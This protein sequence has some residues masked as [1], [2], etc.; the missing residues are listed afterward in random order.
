MYNIK[1]TIFLGFLHFPGLIEFIRTIYYM[2]AVQSNENQPK[3][4]NDGK[5]CIEYVPMRACAH[6]IYM[7]QP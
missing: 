7:A 6:R 1:C 5:K 2:C 3:P 4:N